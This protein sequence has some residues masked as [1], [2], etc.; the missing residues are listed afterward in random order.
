MYE[1]VIATRDKLSEMMSLVEKAKIAMKNDGIYQWTSRYPNKEVILEDIMNRDMFLLIDNKKIMSMASFHYDLEKNSYLLKRLVSN[2]DEVN[3]GQASILYNN[4]EK[5]ARE[6]E[7]SSIY[8]STNHTNYKMIN[9]FNKNNF[10]LVNQYFEKNREE[11]G[12]FY[13]YRKNVVR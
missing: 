4:L 10:I 8:S 13:L 11:Y 7:V 2:A 12:K 6:L 9:F 5:K 1:I 3:Q